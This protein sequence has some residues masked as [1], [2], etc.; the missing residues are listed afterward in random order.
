MV[1]IEASSGG[2]SFDE[3]KKCPS[4]SLFITFG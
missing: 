4:P 1:R 3:Y 2:F